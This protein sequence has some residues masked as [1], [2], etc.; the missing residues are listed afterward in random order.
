MAYN[1]PIY[2]APSVP[3]LNRTNI[4]SPLKG[5][6][7]SSGLQINKSSFSFRP[8]SPRVEN[9]TPT[10]ENKEQSK[11]SLD[12]IASSLVETNRVLVEIQNQLAID[13]STRIAED[14]KQIS[15]LKKQKFRKAA[16]NKE[17][18]LE[19]I[20]G[21]GKGIFKQVDKV[22]TPAKN[23]FEKIVEFFKTIL[24]GLIVNTVLNWLSK[25]EN[26][27]KVIAFFNFLADH[28]KWIVGTLIAGKLLGGLLRLIGIVRGIKRIIDL[29]RG[30]GK[31]PG[32]RVGGGDPCNPRTGLLQCMGNPAFSS[33][34]VNA[35]ITAFLANKAFN[36]RIEDIVNGKIPTPTPVPTLPRLT[37]QQQFAQSRQGVPAGG[38]SAANVQAAQAAQ[39]NYPDVDWGAIRDWGLVAVSVATP[40]D[41]GV[42]GDVL[43]IANLLKNGRITA[44]ALRSIVGK[45]AV[46]KILSYMKSNNISPA[47]AR[48]VGGVIPTLP[49]QKKKCNSCSLGFSQ[50]GSVGG[51][52]S[53]TVD[54]VPAMLA[55]GEYVIRTAASK[56]F[57]PLLSDINENAGRL[58][59]Y[60]REAVTKLLDVTSLQQSNSERFSTVLEDLN[61]TFKQKKQR[62]T[63]KKIGDLSGGGKGGGFGK[64]LFEKAGEII[65]TQKGKSAGIHGG[66]WVGGQVGRQKGG[67]MY[68]NIIQKI[69]NVNMSPVQNN[70]NIVPLPIRSSSIQQ[71]TKSSSNSS[72]IIVPINLPTKKAE[73]PKI[74]LAQAPASYVPSIA[75]SNTSNPYMVLTP[76]LYGIFV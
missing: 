62:E 54:S 44:A 73:I 9:L 4:S 15:E 51:S 66:G 42:A 8:P 53:G 33:A 71:I 68:D 52:G 76:S 49:I 1:F 18:A 17:A 13:F 70:V 35:S 55:P 60:F 16:F 6:I 41:A 23:L 34:F 24:T 12:V 75:A 69:P 11:I 59:N 28:W 37:P 48:S 2:R 43:A 5:N 7:G 21:I 31:L 72:P 30:K 22:L 25:K 10:P 40:L 56:L 61:N 63:V 47:V 50:G 57:R 20:Q 58:W 67:Q 26:Q 14:K 32:G 3:K 64:P 45:Q 38:Y 27:K 46:D 29:L 19:N 65:G 39:K 36:D 74:N